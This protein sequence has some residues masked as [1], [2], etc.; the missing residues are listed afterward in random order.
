MFDCVT[1][2]V[3]LGSQGMQMYTQAAGHACGGG[4]TIDVK[5]RACWKRGMHSHILMESK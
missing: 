5:A 2:D 3:G 4:V 1:V